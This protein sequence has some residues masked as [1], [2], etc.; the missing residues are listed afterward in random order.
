[1]IDIADRTGRQEVREQQKANFG[2]GGGSLFKVDSAGSREGGQRLKEL[3][4]TIGQVYD[5]ARR[6]AWIID[7]LKVSSRGLKVLLQSVTVL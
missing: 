4:D 6:N 1:M 7:K 2:N 5:M 3:Q